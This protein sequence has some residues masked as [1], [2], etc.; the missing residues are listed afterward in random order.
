M[1]HV[2][3]RAQ[4]R[5]RLFVQ[6]FVWLIVI[7]TI[8]GGVRYPL[9]GF[10]VAAVMMIGL[11][12]ALIKGRYVCGWLCPRGALFDRILKPI[13]LGRGIPQWLRDYRFR[14]AVF[15]SLMGVVAF[16]VSH[17]PGRCLSLGAGVRP[18]LHHYDRERRAAGSVPSSAR[19][20]RILSHGHPTERGRR[21]ARAP[22]RGGRLQGMSN[23]RTSLPHEPA[24]RGQHHE[25]PARQPRLPEVPG[26]PT[27]MP[28]EDPALLTPGMYRR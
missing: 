12:G 20:V 10:V 28:E 9:L 24:D 22:V 4:S 25:R 13:S 16:Q 14:W 19:M 3:Y 5:R 15:A 11:I 26:M 1:E 7:I 23:V 6:S 18:R 27:G 17:S 2:D 21:T 8:F